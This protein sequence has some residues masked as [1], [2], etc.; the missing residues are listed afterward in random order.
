MYFLCIVGIR[1]LEAYPLRW[2]MVVLFYFMHL[3]FLLRTALILCF[4]T[5]NAREVSVY[6]SLLKKKERKKVLFWLLIYLLLWF[7]LCLDIFIS[8]IVFGSISQK[9]ESQEAKL[10]IEQIYDPI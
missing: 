8:I 9:L 6:S 2:I 7:L 1:E 5:L 3:A 4:I 10:P